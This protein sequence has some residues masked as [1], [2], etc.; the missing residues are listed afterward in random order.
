MDLEKDAAFYAGFLEFFSHMEH[1]NLDDIRCRPLDR[2]IDGRPFRKAAAVEVLCMDVR[3]IT[4]PAKK[5]LYISHFTGF[6][7]FPFHVFLNARIAG[8]V[9]VNILSGFASGHTKLPAKTEIA[10]AIDDAKI[11]GLCFAAHERRYVLNGHAKD[12]R[13]RPAM[14][15]LAMTEGV[16]EAFIAGNACH[17]AQFNLGIITAHEE[18]IPFAGYKHPAH[19]LAYFRPGR[20]VLQIW[21][22][23][24][25]PSGHGRHLIEMGMDAARIGIDEGMERH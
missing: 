19:L 15:I 14:D 7:L 12:F 1:G 11:Y 8:K 6:L 18:V 4:A 21:I 24:G 20:D 22:R 13:G 25:K 23:T 16:N 3:Q 5:G 2:C 10:D 9:A 17:D